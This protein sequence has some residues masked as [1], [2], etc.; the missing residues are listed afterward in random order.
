MQSH[1]SEYT[2]NIYQPIITYELIP[3]PI[4]ASTEQK[5]SYARCASQVLLNSSIAITAINIPEIHDE[6]KLDH[7]ARPEAYLVKMDN[8]EFA[9]LLRNELPDHID[10]IINH[11]TVYDDWETQKGWLMDT[12]ERYKL[13]NLILVGGDCSSIKYPGPS[14]IDF[15]KYIKSERKHSCML[16]RHNYSFTSL[17][18]TC[19]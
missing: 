17:F 13:H 16:G 12:F 5:I 3:P 11:C 1:F 14:V 8:R 7:G 9:N 19:S 10:Y 15:A 4:T 6:K 2:N 18:K